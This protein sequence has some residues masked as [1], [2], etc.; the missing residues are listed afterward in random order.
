M[1]KAIVSDG[2]ARNLIASFAVD[3]PWTEI[4]VD[5]Q[6]FIELTPIERGQRFAEFL[7]NGLQTIAGSIIDAIEGGRTE[8]W[9]HPEQKTEWVQGRKILKYLTD[10]GELAGCVD[11]ADLKAIQAKGIDFFRKHFRGKA[12]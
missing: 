1:S 11:L 10:S 9:L 5:V 3:T 7:R 6:P 8:L 2:Q 12:G 4:E